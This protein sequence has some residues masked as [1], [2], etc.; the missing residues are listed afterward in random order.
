MGRL[1]RACVCKHL[2]IRVVQGRFFGITSLRLQSKVKLILTIILQK[3]LINFNYVTVN[4]HYVCIHPSMHLC[5]CVCVYVFVKC[6]CMHLYIILCSAQPEVAAVLDWYGPE[7]DPAYWQTGREEVTGLQVACEAHNLHVGGHPP[8]FRP[9]YTDHVSIYNNK[10]L[11]L[12]CRLPLPGHRYILSPFDPY[13]TFMHVQFMCISIIVYNY[14]RFT[15]EHA[16]SLN[17]ST[18]LPLYTC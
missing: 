5:L 9:S 6:V 4:L 10:L 13:I 7:A 18:E 11:Y 1:V 14:I 8:E 17:F 2:Y 12:L 15:T 16:R 3:Y